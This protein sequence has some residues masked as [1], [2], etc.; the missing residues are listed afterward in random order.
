MLTAVLTV[1][2]HTPSLRTR[3]MTMSPI[4]HSTTSSCIPMVRVPPE[5]QTRR[6][7]STGGYHLHYILGTRGVTDT[8]SVTSTCLARI[9][10]S[11]LGTAG[12]AGTQGLPPANHETVSPP[13]YYPCA[14]RLTRR[15]TRLCG[16]SCKTA[17]ILSLPVSVPELLKVKT[18]S[19]RRPVPL[20]RPGQGSASRSSTSS[21]RRLDI[22]RC[23]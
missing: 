5:I 20:P 22:R 8:P 4:P 9:C 7:I 12:L 21:R 3:L 13:P 18:V 10:C 14:G 2:L 16:T 19:S 17:S 23:Q 1:S 15:P 11:G 6:F